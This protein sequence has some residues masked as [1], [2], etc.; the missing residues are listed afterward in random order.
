MTKAISDENN[1]V[2]HLYDI[3]EES[4]VD[5][6]KIRKKPVLVMYYGDV[7]GSISNIDLKTLEQTFENHLNKFGKKHFRS[8]DFIIHTTGGD[9]NTSYRLIQLIRSYTDNLTAL[10]PKHAYS[11]G[12]LITF[13]SDIIEMGRTATLSPIDVQL[14]SESRT[15]PLLAIENYIEFISDCAKKY[16]FREEE[17]KARF[18][19]KLTEQLLEEISPQEL[20]EFFRLRSLTIHH[21]KTLLTNYMFKNNSMKENFANEIISRFTKDTPTHAFEMDYNLVKNSMLS[22]RLMDD[23]T[24]KLTQSILEIVE[25]LKNQGAIC[26]FFPYN[27]R[28]RMPY[29]QIFDGNSEPREGDDDGKKRI[30]KRG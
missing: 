16:G 3:F 14:G 15:F 30:S 4:V 9:A 2:R 24:Y 7:A 23:K 20:G 22:V 10:V 17:N 5:L 21:A 29:F 12:T 26:E 18:V 6:T 25:T 1:E 27:A 19:T 11:G 13:G 8:L 28:R